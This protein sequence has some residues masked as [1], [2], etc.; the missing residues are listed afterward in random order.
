VQDALRR[1]GACR[2]DMVNP[3]PPF[4]A[5]QSPRPIDDK[6][7]TYT[8]RRPLA[9]SVFAAVAANEPR[10]AIRRGLAVVGLLPG[11]SAADPI[12]RV[13]GASPTAR[14]CAPTSSSMPWGGGR[15]GRL[16]FSALRRAT[17]AD[18]RG[19]PRSGDAVDDP[20]RSLTTSARGRYASA[21]DNASARADLHRIGEQSNG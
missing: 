8:A 17:R 16:R 5:D 3:L 6:L 14:R 4:F 7:W 18:G 11:A 2:L 19:R 13:A 9:E 15:G 21:I 10:I 12:P 20:A 1:A